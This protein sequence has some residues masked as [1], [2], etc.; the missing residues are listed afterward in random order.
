M[1]PLRIHSIVS[2]DHSKTILDAFNKLMEKIGHLPAKE[3][4]HPLGIIGKINWA[5]AWNKPKDIGRK[6]VVVATNDSFC[7]V[8][9]FNQDPDN[10]IL[11]IYRCEDITATPVYAKPKK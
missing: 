4:I 11:S 5:A 2:E 7:M 8:E 10:T 6:C 9:L 3:V 1:E